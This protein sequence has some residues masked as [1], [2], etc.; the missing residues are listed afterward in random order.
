MIEANKRVPW[1][2]VG[3]WFAGDI[4]HTAYVTAYPSSAPDVHQYLVSV[5]KPKPTIDLRIDGKSC[6]T[7]SKWAFLEAL[8]DWLHA[9]YD[10]GDRTYDGLSAFIEQAR[11]E[12][13]QPVEAA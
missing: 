3:I 4:G 7:E 10:A 13:L 2:K 5:G 9:K 12:Y 6:T 1:Q 8:I 11:V